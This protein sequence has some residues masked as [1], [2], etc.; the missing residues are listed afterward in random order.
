MPVVPCHLEPL[1]HRPGVRDGRGE[2]VVPEW[3]ELESR[4]LFSAAP[5]APVLPSQAP[6]V[7]IALHGRGTAAV[8]GQIETSGDVDVFSLT[9]ANDG[10]V[11]VTVAASSGPGTGISGDL[12]AYGQT[13]LLARDADAATTGAAVSFDVTAGA[14]Y[15]LRVASLNDKTGRY[16]LKV[17]GVWVS[18]PPVVPGPR[19]SWRVENAPGGPRLVVLGTNGP[20]A[21][22]VSRASGNTLIYVS[23]ALAWT[24]SQV[25]SSVQVYGFGGDD[26]LVSVSGAGETVRGGAGLDSFW[27]DSADSFP[28]VSAAETSAGRVHVVDTFYTPA[29]APAASLELAGQDLPDPATRYPYRRYSANA[30]F[31][32]G[33]QYNDVFQ[34]V[35]DD[36]SFLAVLASLA[37][38]RPTLIRQMIAPLGDGTYAVRF[39]TDGRASY[40][41]LDPDLPVYD[42]STFPAYA[43]L[44]D[45]GE[46]WVALLEKAFAVFHTGANSYDSI[47]S[48]WMSPIYAQLTGVGAGDTYTAYTTEADLAGRIRR[49]IRA[50]HGVTVASD[51]AGSE[52]VVG[53]HAYAVR[54]IRTVKGQTMVTVF[55]P[56]GVD[57]KPDD[58]DTVDGL[59]TLTMTQFRHVFT[60]LSIS[61]A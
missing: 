28:D 19:V 24:S 12:S 30:L 36:C 25:F 17:S 39:F 32:D 54:S 44:T 5:A 40:V 13:V 9:P 37:Q 58:D 2:P 57:G 23:G 15:I 1:F 4:L 60:T 55:N 42:G 53:D 20:D 56:W 18:P 61:D 48:E 16:S 29:S 45:D 34:G 31:G 33:P 51:S 27:G 8:S 59:V 26:L 11:T 47:S 46:L 52:A 22:T 43:S 6:V 14:T 3:G 38:S 41:R 35:A 10:R 49:A 50:G 7:A 21:I